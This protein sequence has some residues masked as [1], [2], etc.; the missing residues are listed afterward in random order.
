MPR[1]R[2]ILLLLVVTTLALPACSLKSTSTACTAVGCSSGAFV[3]LAAF[4]GANRAVT[5]AIVCIDDHCETHSATAPGATAPIALARASAITPLT[6][7]ATVTV[8]VTLKGADGRVLASDSTRTRLRKN[9]PN[10]PTC[11]PTCYVARLRITPAG[12]LAEDLAI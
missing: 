8:K 7:E 11:E 4:T 9:Q 6:E 3:D 10:G 2:W 5:E 12:K 1:H